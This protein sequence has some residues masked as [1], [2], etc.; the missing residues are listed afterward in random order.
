[1][2]DALLNAEVPVASSC[3]GDAVC[4]KCKVNVLEG[5]E[6][7]SPVTDA[8]QFRKEKLKLGS[9]IRLSC[10]AKVIGDIKIDTTYW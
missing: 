7:L 8:E 3:H 1:M 10:Q 9:D 2:M 5:A 6:N 4:G